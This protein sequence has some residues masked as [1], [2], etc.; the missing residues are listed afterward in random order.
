M[1]EGHSQ[2]HALVK[3]A[4]LPGLVLGRPVA[5]DQPKPKHLPQQPLTAAAPTVT[6]YV[7]LQVLC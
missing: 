2:S 3:V 7:L 4:K 5:H 6:Q 1:R